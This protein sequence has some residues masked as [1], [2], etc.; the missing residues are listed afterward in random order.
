MK[1]KKNLI[2]KGYEL[3]HIVAFSML[4]ISIVLYPIAWGY[5]IWGVGLCVIGLGFVQIVIGIFAKVKPELFRLKS[6]S[7]LDTW[8]VLS[9]VDLLVFFGSIHFDLTEITMGAMLIGVVLSLVQYSALTSKKFK[10]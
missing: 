8:I 9:V 6:L 10:H 5:S 4:I 2:E 1:T 7:R 3:F